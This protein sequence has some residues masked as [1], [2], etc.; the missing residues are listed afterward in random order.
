[1]ALAMVG[2]YAAAAVVAY[3]LP[4]IM[5][6]DSAH[7]SRWFSSIVGQFL[8][9]VLAEATIV[10][11]IVWFLRRR[12][13]SVKALGFHR[14]PMWQDALYVL[15]TFG[16]YFIAVALVTS[17]VKIVFHIDLDQKQELGF[18]SVASSSDKLLTFASLVIIPPVVEEF[19]FRGFLFGGLRTKLPFMWA[20]II[21]SLLFA[22]LHLAEGSGGVLW[23][24]GIDTFILS[25]FLCFLRERT[26][27]LW[28]GILLHALKNSVAFL[29]L[30]V[31][32]P[33]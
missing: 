25:L 7:A 15:V 5:R 20:A 23:V 3:L 14:R 11:F 13:T 33:R 1:M 32:I 12:R 30:Y 24:A 28:S 26:G 27:N 16:A 31:F 21:T 10:A 9:V 29:Y 19:L 6:W 18:D 22:S 2:A 4:Q 17:V 8:F